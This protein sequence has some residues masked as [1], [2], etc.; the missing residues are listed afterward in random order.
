M[1]PQTCRDSLAGIKFLQTS[2]MEK[3]LLNDPAQPPTD[4]LLGK[5]LNESY[6][7]Y[8]AMIDEVTSPGCG[9]EPMWRYYNDGKSWLCKMVFK[10]KTVFWLSVWDGFFK[11]GF[12]F[13]ERHLQ[14]IGELDIDPGIREALSKAKPSGTLYPV[15]L[16]MRKKEQIGD[17]L[18]LIEYRKKLK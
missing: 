14:G 3:P 18:R 16:E 4:E 13:L 9:L 7:V 17:L 10:K 11:A 2:K 5:I 15:T 1:I 12:Y 6:P 8:V